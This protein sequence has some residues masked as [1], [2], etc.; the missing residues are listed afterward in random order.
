VKPYDDQGDHLLGNYLGPTGSSVPDDC[1]AGSDLCTDNGITTPRELG[2]GLP[3]T[4]AG[5][6]AWMLFGGLILLVGGCLLVG[7]SRRREEVA[8]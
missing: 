1:A 7:L 6:S 2:S 3:D 8:R 4:G 5:F